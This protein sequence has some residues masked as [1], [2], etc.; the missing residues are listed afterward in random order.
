MGRISR[1]VETEALCPHTPTLSQHIQN[2]LAVQADNKR[3]WGDFVGE[4]HDTDIASLSVQSMSAIL[5]V[6][7]T[8]FME[9]K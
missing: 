7:S 2:D 8:V 6:S 1:A 3:I 4:N 5:L 9:C